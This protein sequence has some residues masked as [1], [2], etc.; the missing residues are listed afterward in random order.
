MIRGGRFAR[1]GLVLPIVL[2]ALNTVYLSAAL[3]IESQFSSG[4]GIGPRT[5]PILV[6]LCMYVALVV[7]LYGELRD[8]GASEPRGAVIRPALVVLATA[9]YIFLFRPLGY[10]IDTALY[11]AVLF[12]VF[13]FEI[14]RPHFFAGY[15]IL[16][17]VA[18][19]GLFAGVF[20]VRLPPLPG[21]L[22]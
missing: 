17:A 6:S 3:N 21:G 19:Y 16:V 12:G 2:I 20:G 10:W 8:D 15:V 9:G 4:A 5:V 22:G 14:R 18:F 1:T 7:V 13:Q 11:V